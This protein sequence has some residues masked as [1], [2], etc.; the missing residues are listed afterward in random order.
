[1]VRIKELHARGDETPPE[2]WERWEC[3][4]GR[5]IRWQRVVMVLLLQKIKHKH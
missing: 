4:Y 2:G 5:G 3:R 1:M